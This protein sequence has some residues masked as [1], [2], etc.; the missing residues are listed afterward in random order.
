MDLNINSLSLKTFSWPTWSPCVD[1]GPYCK[2]LVKVCDCSASTSNS[3]WTC[4]HWVGNHNH[5]DC[6]FKFQI[7]SWDVK[8]EKESPCPKTW[9]ISWTSNLTVNFGHELEMNQPTGH[10]KTWGQDPTSITQMR[11][12][13]LIF[14]VDHSTNLCFIGTNIIHD[15]TKKL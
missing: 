6:P 5:K 1:L 3:T 7:H 2:S 4:G 13:H 9:S 8:I 15:K 12:L 11:L 14:K 10:S